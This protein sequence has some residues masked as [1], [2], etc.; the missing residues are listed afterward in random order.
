MP[1]HFSGSGI[2]LLKDYDMKKDFLSHFDTTAQELQNLIALS[3]KLK[4]D[5]KKNRRPK[6]LAEKVIALIFEKPSLRTHATFE[7]G[8]VQLGGY[9]LYL[10]GGNVRIGDRETPEDVAHNLERW[11]DGVIIRTYSQKNIEIIAKNAKIPIINALTDDH[12]PCQALATLMALQE[13]CGSLKKL[14]VAFV[15][16]GNNVAV[17]LLG[18]CAKLGIHGAHACPKGYKMDKS[19]WEQIQLDAKKSGA[20]ITVTQNPKDAVKNADLVYT[21]VWTSMGQEKETAKRKKMFK[22]FQVNAKLMSF[23]K[24]NA[25]FSHCLPAHRGEEVTAEILDGPNSIALDEAENR[26]HVQK[27]VMMTL[28]R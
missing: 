4:Q 24:T 22:Q 2:F 11:V 12:H 16:D 13:H 3:I 19:F 10:P 1:G 27:A 5:L 20:E 8:I 6:P 18:M 7:T 9:P 23:A 25:K 14:K 28:I 26:L 15:G 21:D 17:S